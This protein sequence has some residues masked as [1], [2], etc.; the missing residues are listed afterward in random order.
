MHGNEPLKKQPNTQIKMEQPRHSL[1]PHLD[2]FTKSTPSHSPPK[3]HQNVLK[4]AASSLSLGC[5]CPPALAC[6]GHGGLGEGALWL[7][8]E[9][10][11][12]WEL[13]REGALIAD[14][15]S[16]FTL[17][18]PSIQPSVHLSV[19]LICGSRVRSSGGTF[20]SLRW[21][22]VMHAWPHQVLLFVNKLKRADN[23]GSYHYFELCLTN[24]FDQ[25][26][27][28]NLNSLL[29]CCVLVMA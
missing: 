8:G 19:Y 27:S 17:W 5:A 28:Q 18:P 14:L 9:V 26:T 21:R 15:L 24:Y 25:K 11:G 7:G 22:R 3:P 6:Q 12:C 4:T 29:Y 20:I 13:S 1:A 23:E 16:V 2:S 10:V